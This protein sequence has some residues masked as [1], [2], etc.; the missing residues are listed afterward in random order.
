M[1]REIENLLL[2]SANGTSTDAMPQEIADILVGDG[3]VECLKVQLGM[4]PDIIKTA[5][6]GTI[7][8]VTMS[9]L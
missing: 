3:D 8:R 4:L 5:L 1:I 7:K 2:N 6:E 9:E